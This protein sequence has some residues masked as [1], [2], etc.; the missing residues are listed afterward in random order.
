MPP[1]GWDPELE[2]G[3]PLVDRQHRNIHSLFNRLESAED[4]PEEIMRVLESLLD[5][6]AMHFDTEEDLMRR[7]LYPAKLLEEHVRLHRELTGAARQKVLEFR[8]GQLTH[9]R[10][11]VEFLREWIVEHVHQQ[12]RVLIDYVRV[13]GGVASVPEPWASSPPLAV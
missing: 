2:T 12:D 4:R 13:R 9:T 3:D 7:E 11:L 10:P 1:I 8:S 6:V 5:H